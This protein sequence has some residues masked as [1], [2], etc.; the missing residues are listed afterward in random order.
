MLEFQVWKKGKLIIVVVYVKMCCGELIC[1]IIKNWIENFGDLKGFKWEGFS[2]DVGYSI[3][4][5]YFFSFF[6]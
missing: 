5:Y 3:D 1:F 6:L 2:F 4:I